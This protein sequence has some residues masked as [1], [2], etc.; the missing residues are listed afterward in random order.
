MLL[1]ANWKK[2]DCGIADS[3]EG[4]VT[5]AMCPPHIKAMQFWGSLLYVSNVL[6]K[7]EC[8][9][10][11]AVIVKACWFGPLSSD[12]LISLFS[13]TRRTCISMGTNMLVCKKFAQ[14]V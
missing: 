6:R 11:V 9:E 8:N 1:E 7:T 2:M 12:N 13:P 10:Y 3:V 5:E 14:I 4:A